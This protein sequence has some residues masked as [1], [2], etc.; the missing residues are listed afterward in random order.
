MVVALVAVNGAPGARAA[1]STSSKQQRQTE[2]NRRLGALRSQVQEAST[3]EAKLLDQLDSVEAKRKELDAKVGALDAQVAAAQAEL[4]AAS[5]SLD[6]H[7]AALTQAQA[8]LNLAQR[9]LIEAR[10]RLTERAVRAYMGQ[11]DI[12][13]AGRFLQPGSQREMAAAESYVHTLVDAQQELV[14]QYNA[15]QRDLQTREADVQTQRDEAQ[16]QR[17]VVAHRNAEV[18]SARKVQNSARA[19]V[20]AQEQQK[21]A[22]VDQVRSRRQEF[23]TQIAQLKAESNAIT[24]FL[25]GVQKGQGPAI[26]GKGIFASPIPG[27]AITSGFGPRVHPIYGDVRMHTGIDFRA[28]VGTPVRAAG[29]GTIVFAGWRGGYGNAVIIDHGN[30]LA[31]LYGHLSA[32]NVGVGQRVT[33]GQVIARAG[34][35]GLSTGPHL[36]FEVR[37]NGVPVNP[38][39]YL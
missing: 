32:I 4:D 2:I 10:R 12:R 21:A 14:D 13:T 3:E 16:A 22:L 23:E 9:L 37:A 8:E 36:H 33:K 18:Q 24:S 17:D 34:S 31:T 20:L 7:A 38:M 1:T 30:S 15:H 11:P 39:G 25:R 26:S 27:A 19:E 35:T 6:Q 29:T 28:S 5:A